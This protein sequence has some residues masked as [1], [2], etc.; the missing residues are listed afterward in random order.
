MYAIEFETDLKGG[1]LTLPDDYRSLNN[2]HV[3]VVMLLENHP[4]DPELRAFSEHSAVAIPEW[5]DAA[6]DEVWK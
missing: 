1:V 3:R 6:E 2:Q 4:D 5:Q